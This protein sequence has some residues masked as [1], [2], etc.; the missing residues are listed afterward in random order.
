MIRIVVIFLLIGLTSLGWADDVK[1]HKKPIVSNHTQFDH[2]VWNG[3][4]IKF[5]API[6]QERIL[7]FPKPVSVQIQSDQLTTDKV[8][9]QNNNGYLYITAHKTFESVRIPVRL[10]QSGEV[11]LV[12]LL[13]TQNAP[14]RPVSVVM[15]NH[16]KRQ[17]GSHHQTKQPS[18]INYVTLTRYAM[19]HLY[20]PK[21]LIH[22]NNKIGRTPMYTDKAVNLFDNND[23]VAKPLISWQGNHLYVTAV[24]LHNVKTQSV[25]INPRAI[26][27]KWLTVSF[28]PN[29]SL[30]PHGHDNDTTTAFLVSDKPFNKALQQVRGRY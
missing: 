1:P 18:F 14:D 9:I 19:Q 21:R 20:A 11:I 29:Q 15:K 25:N 12:D 6:G 24:L 17:S 16:V 30:K 26:Q 28:Y 2:A 4:P 5:K 10:R 13:A 8:S 27:G 22:D 3:I 7:K 23:V